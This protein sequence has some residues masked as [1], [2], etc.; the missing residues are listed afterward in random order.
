MN[1]AF[2]SGPDDIYP[3]RL[4]ACSFGQICS[5]SVRAADKDGPNED[6]IALIPYDEHSGLIAVADGLGGHARGD[7]A[8]RIAVE[9]LAS[10]LKKNGGDRPGLRDA[11]LRGIDDANRKILS[12]E[13]GAATTAIVL[14]ISGNRIRT[15]HAGDSVALIAGQKGKLKFQTISHSPVGYA[16]ESGLI[17]E[18]EAMEADDRHI[19]SNI[20]GCTNMRIEM[21]P[22][23][24]LAP[25]DTVL[26]ASDGLTDNMIIDDIVE[27]IRKGPLQDAGHRLMDACLE[28]M[29][30][31]DG[32]MDDLS[33]IL[34]RLPDS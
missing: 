30:G 32:H 11:I 17:N 23:L 33:V 18:A 13:I 20:V 29:H 19:V 16:L 2:I 26:L 27:L 8:S 1:D 10:S 25:R 21:G 5:F 7:Q 15:Y 3:P 31:S 28:N 9:A 12:L 6:S 22:L 14:E 4:H 34:F 24:K